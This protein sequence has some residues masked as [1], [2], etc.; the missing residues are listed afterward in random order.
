MKTK[1]YKITFLWIA[2]DETNTFDCYELPSLHLCEYGLFYEID[3]I[4]GKKI[5][6]DYCEVRLDEIQSYEKEV[7]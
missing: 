5:A 2:N 1:V 4:Q 6:L 3:T 7:N